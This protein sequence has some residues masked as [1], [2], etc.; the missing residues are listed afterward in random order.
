MSVNITVTVLVS[1]FKSSFCDTLLNLLGVEN[2]AV[3]F[4]VVFIVLDNG[5]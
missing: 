5:E 1:I 3:V 2:R 4:N